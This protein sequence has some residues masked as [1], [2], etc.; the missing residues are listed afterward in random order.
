MR[1][2]IMSGMMM[3]L[4]LAGCGTASTKAVEESVSPLPKAV[5]SAM[6]PQASEMVK[7][8]QT[9]EPEQPSILSSGIAEIHPKET[10]EA[11]PAP[12]P[13]VEHIVEQYRIELKG[14]QASC[15]GKVQ[16]IVQEMADFIKSKDAKSG[17]EWLNQ[18]Q[19]QYLGEVQQAENS[20]DQTFKGIMTRAE[21]ALGQMD[22]SAGI[23]EAWKKEY[24]QTKA[25]AK[26]AAISQL[27]S[28]VI[29][30]K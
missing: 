25:Q 12:P 2:W 20:C 13:T 1:R 6:E 7:P 17:Q 28:L 26:E 29:S 9:M 19:N 8:S 10:T 4:I 21:N 23:L 30:E 22:G 16:Q 5:I 15:S 3:T 11:T 14:L 18:L 27:V 24:L